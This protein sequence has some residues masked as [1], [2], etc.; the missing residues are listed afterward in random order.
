MAN[1]TL[2]I[3]KNKVC[4]QFVSNLAGRLLLDRYLCIFCV[5]VVLAPN[6]TNWN[7]ISEY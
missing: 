2:K 4:V 6:N 5:G 7:V 1:L 3:I